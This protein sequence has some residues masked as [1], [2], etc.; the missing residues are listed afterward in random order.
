MPSSRIPGLALALVLG[1]ASASFVVTEGDCV[2]DGDCVS[3]PGY[4]AAY[5]AYL[6]CTIFPESAGWLDVVGW[7]LEE[8]W[9]G[10]Y[11]DDHLTVN[12]VQYCGEGVHAGPQGVAVNPATEITFVAD[13]YNGGHGGFDICLSSTFTSTEPPPTATPTIG[14]CDETATHF[15]VTEGNCTACGNCFYSPN[16]VQGG[17]YDHYHSCTISPLQSGYLDVEAFDLED[18][19]SWYGC[20]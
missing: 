7:E 10:N 15:S 18:G 20:R 8:S 5:D 4:P 9:W 1:S 11:C 6:E 13:Y 2:V 3:S 14:P 16:H 17:S 12:G 19:Y